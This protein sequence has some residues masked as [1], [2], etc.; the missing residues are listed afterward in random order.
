[1]QTGQIAK[2]SVENL[3]AVIKIY[4]SVLY[5]HHALKAELLN[6]LP[7]PLK[8]EILSEIRIQEHD[9]LIIDKELEKWSKL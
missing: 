3:E 4:A 1:M 7:R 5:E 6:M 9:A 2:G 8:Q